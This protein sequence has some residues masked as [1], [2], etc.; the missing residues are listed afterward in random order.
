MG[1]SFRGRYYV[2]ALEGK[3]PK[4]PLDWP[5]AGRCMS[6]VDQGYRY[7]FNLPCDWVIVTSI[8]QIRL[9]CK[10]CDQHTYELFDTE[11]LADD[12]I[13]IQRIAFHS[14][15]ALDDFGSFFLNDSTINEPN[16]CRGC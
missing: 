10:G 6:A 14:R 9:Y 15:F 3:G 4:D 7:A 2:A 16:D 12:E 13:C 8:R 1:K 5:F 11:R